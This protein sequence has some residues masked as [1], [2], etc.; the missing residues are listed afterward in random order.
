MQGLVVEFEN[1]LI[2]N[3]SEDLTCQKRYVYGNLF[4]KNDYTNYVIFV[5]NI[6][7]LS[8]QLHMKQRTE[9]LSLF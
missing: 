3:L 6:F 9:T 8:T 1:N 2:Q 7:H 4:I 5:L